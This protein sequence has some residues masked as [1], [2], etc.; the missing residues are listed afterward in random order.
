MTPLGNV[1]HCCNKEKVR[2]STKGEQ[3]P[4][5][6]LQH[7]RRTW[8]YY[9]EILN[10]VEVLTL[11]FL[12]LV[13]LF[14]GAWYRARSRATLPQR[15]SHVSWCNCDSISPHPI[16]VLT[17]APMLDSLSGHQSS[18]I[19]KSF[20]VKP[21]HHFH[22]PSNKHSTDSKQKSDPGSGQLYF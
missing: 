13:N 3:I 11:S 16:F 8:N 4:P 10:R 18:L 5:L 21:I 12:I 1:G 15:Q 2:L 14:G 9:S 17:P 6:F 22:S 20:C 19:S 7:F